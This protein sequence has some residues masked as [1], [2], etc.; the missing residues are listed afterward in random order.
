M[1]KEQF[2]E[3]LS[4]REYRSEITKAEAELAK[5][6]GL[7]VVT[8][9]SDDNME[10]RGA[11]NDEVGCYDGGTAYLDETGLFLSAC[12]CENCLYAKIERERCKMIHAIW[13]GGDDKPPWIFETEI[14]HATFNVYED[15]ELWCV[16]I[17][18]EMAELRR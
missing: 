5:E 10:F 4:G 9:Y 16:G 13:C 11:I 7:V 6:A 18:F 15:G 2:A 12:D 14:P 3:R 1:T 8:A 17:V